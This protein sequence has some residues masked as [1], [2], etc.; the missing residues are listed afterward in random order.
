[1]ANHSHTH[2]NAELRPSHSGRGTNRRDFIILRA[3]RIIYN[4]QEILVNYGR[5]YGFDEP[6]SHSTKYMKQS[7]TNR[8]QRRTR[9][10]ID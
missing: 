4:R 8:E 10:V 2:Y 3:R 5:E 6:T 1:M 7:R 9:F